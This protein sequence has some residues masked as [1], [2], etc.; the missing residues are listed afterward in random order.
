MSSL[1]YKEVPLQSFLLIEQVSSLKAHHLNLLS[2]VITVN[3]TVTAAAQHV[4][5]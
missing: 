3:N 5:L 4:K 2:P 1:L